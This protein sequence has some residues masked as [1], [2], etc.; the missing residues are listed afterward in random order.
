[1]SKAVN[2]GKTIRFTRRL[3]WAAK[4]RER[5]ETRVAAVIGIRSWAARRGDA[6]LATLAEALRQRLAA[7]NQR[8]AAESGGGRAA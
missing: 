7:Y 2:K 1:M 8:L 3:R 4:R 5:G 6:A